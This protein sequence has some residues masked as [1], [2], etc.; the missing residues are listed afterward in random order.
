M[1]PP[2][3]ITAASC[4][5]DLV[6]ALGLGGGLVCLLL[7][8]SK[9]ATWGWGSPAVLVLL[10]AAPLVLGAWTWWELRT[11]A[12]LVDVRVTARPLILTTNAASVIVAFAMYAS[13]LLMPQLLQLPQQ[14]GH[15]L[16]QSMT[17]AGLWMAPAGLMMMS[18]SP[19]GARLS[20][21]TSPKVTLIGGSCV[22][23]L[24]YGLSP[25]LIERPWG[26]WRSPASA[27]PASP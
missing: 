11:E 7:G 14:T 21:A 10:A 19:L 1:I 26:C 20:A 22:I 16:G 17:A 18:I 3:P 27:T 12:P 23:A 6:G 4:S 15:G 13:P 8:V 24:G 25:L 9:G 2:T 5:F